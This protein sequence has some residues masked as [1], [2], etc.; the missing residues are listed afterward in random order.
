MLANGEIVI[1]NAKNKYSDLFKALKGGGGGNFGVVIRFKF[2]LVSILPVVTTFRLRWDKPKDVKAIVKKWAELHAEKDGVD[3]ALSATCTMLVQKSAKSKKSDVHARMGGKFYGSKKK[4]ETLLRKYFGDLVPKELPSNTFTQTPKSYSDDPKQ[5]KSSISSLKKSAP[6][7]S[8]TMTQRMLSDFINPMGSMENTEHIGEN[9][10]ER[11]LTILPDN[12]PSSTCDQPHPHKVSSSFPKDDVNHGD[13]VEAIYKYL[14]DTCY[15]SDV[16]MYM[17]FH[18]MGGAVKRST[19][20]S[21]G[22]SQKPY[23]LQIQAWWDDV[24]NAFTNEARNI[25]YLKWVKDFRESIA[26]HT[27]G[28]FINFVDKTLVPDIK[29]DKNRLKLLEIYYTKKNLETLREVKAKYDKNNLFNFQ[30]SILPK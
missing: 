13:L 4:L 26:E 17:S 23:M 27:E 9:C 24:S 18:C 11:K 20:N 10:K 6:E 30:M 29:K 21:F 15:R 12:G 7:L 25:E 5:K 2:N 19:G 16:N 28:S 3:E 22:Y 8:Y 14:K 1:A